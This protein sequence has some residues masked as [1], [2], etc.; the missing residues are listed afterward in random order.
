MSDGQEITPAPADSLPP[1]LRGKVPKTAEAVT[2]ELLRLNGKDRAQVFKAFNKLPPAAT[3]GDMMTSVQMT[4][5]QGPLPPA[6]E[7]ERYNHIVPGGA[8]RLFAMV[9]KQAEHRMQLENHVAREQVK[10]SGR[11]QV[12]ALVIGVTGILSA[13]TIGTMGHTAVAIAITTGSL[14]TLAVTFLVGK[15]Q[16][17]ASRQAKGG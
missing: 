2:A 11:G 16:E 15:R 1:A 12:F 4:S 17:R 7:L 6:A 13:A 10:Q 14:G 3:T 9:E 8:E 5:W